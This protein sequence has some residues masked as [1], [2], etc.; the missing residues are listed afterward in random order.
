MILFIIPTVAAL[1]LP[2]YVI[3]IKRLV[4]VILHETIV[5]V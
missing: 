1:K 5:V 2:L 3:D 4:S